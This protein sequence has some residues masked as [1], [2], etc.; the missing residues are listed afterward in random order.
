MNMKLTRILTASFF[1]IAAQ[2]SFAQSNDAIGG[3][4]VYQYL[5]IPSSA[6]VASLGGTYIT[7]KDDDINCGMQAPSLLN[8]EM[9]KALSFSGVAYADGIKFGNVAF[10]KHYDKIGTFLAAMN[11]ASYGQFMETDE[12]GTVV[13]NFTASDYGLTLGF[14]RELNRLFSYG[15]AIKF[16]YSD[17]YVMNSFGIAADLSATYCDTTNKVT[18]TF[19]IRN[20]GAQLNNYIDGANEPL[21]AEALIGISKR[22]AHTPLRFNL[23]YRHLEQF[24]LTYTDPYDLGDVDPV[25]G[26]AQVKTIGFWNKLSR[27]FIISSEIL[28]TKNFHLNAG[29]NFQRR[30]ELQV[31]TRPALTGFSFGV[32]MKISKFIISYGRAS[33]HLAGGADHF[34]ITTNLAEFVK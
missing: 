33:Y 34:S 2:S 1:L 21:P 24:D 4:Y 22:L 19:Q 20:V 6:R 27:H 3:N 13:G 28:I 9:S 16:L 7:V 30:Q 8:S 23:T 31:S 14:G 15:A 5:N 29:Y 32:S 11:F 26:E 17:Y 18:A 12:F 10:A 25:T